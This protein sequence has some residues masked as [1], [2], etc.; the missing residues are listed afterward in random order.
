MKS[1][2][3]SEIRSFVVEVGILAIGG[4]GSMLF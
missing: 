1:E 3:E 2:S 4:A